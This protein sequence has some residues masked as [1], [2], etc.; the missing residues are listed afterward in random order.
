MSDFELRLGET[1]VREAP[2]LYRRGLL[3]HNGIVTLTNRRFHFEPKGLDKL[4]GAKPLTLELLEMKKVSRKGVDGILEISMPGI[5]HRLMGDATKE[6]DQAIRDGIQALE[7]AAPEPIVVGPGERIVLSAPVE[8]R[9]DGIQVAT[10][11]VTIT[12]ERLCFSP[13]GRPKFASPSCAF[14]HRLGNVTQVLMTGALAVGVSTAEG[15]V[16][17]VGPAAAA[18]FGRL[19]GGQMLPEWPQPG[20]FR[21]FDAALHYG[22]HRYPGQF[23]LTREAIVFAPDKP[24]PGSPPLELPLAG[25]N[26][27]GSVGVDGH[28]LFVRHGAD[29]WTFAMRD[30]DL[31]LRELWRL[32]VEQPETGAA[33]ATARVTGDDLAATLRALEPSVGPLQVSEVTLSVR[34]VIASLP[35]LAQRGTLVM[36]NNRLWLQPATGL[37]EADAITSLTAGDFESTSIDGVGVVFRDGQQLVEFQC[38]DESLMTTLRERLALLTQGLTGASNRRAS[39]RASPTRRFPIRF[40]LGNGATPPSKWIAARVAD[41]S[42]EGCQIVTDSAIGEGNDVLVELP[43]DRKSLVLASTVMNR[44]A[45]SGLVSSWRYGIRFGKRTPQEDR[46]LRE[47]WMTFQREETARRRTR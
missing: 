29:R 18:V 9:T 5:V 10:G 6:L 41:L 30:V 36:A 21:T 24:A 46:Q 14:D 27:C 17:L 11:E 2:C 8:L 23:R 47:L 32:L 37:R 15:A 3:A 4:T 13:A 40:A 44:R 35:D 20:G 22:E 42:A 45:P 28:V 16:E 43:I 25:V 38:R 1:I 12:T 26:A 19:A 31:R 39:Y 34:G 7:Q 33:A